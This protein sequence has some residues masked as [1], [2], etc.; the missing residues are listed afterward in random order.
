[1][2]VAVR[3]AM[4]RVYL[5]DDHPVVRAGLRAML[6]AAGHQVAGEAEDG[7]AAAAEIARLEPDVVVL[8]LQLG[9]SSGLELL[10]RLRQ[11]KIET[12]VVVLTLSTQPQ[13]IAEA[14][15]AG[16]IG[17]LAKGAVARELLAAIAEVAAGRRYLGSGIAERAVAGFTEGPS[18][19]PLSA[20]ERQIVALVVRG[21]S[22]AEVGAQLHLSPKTVDTY[23][24][25][26]MAKVGVD[27]LPA[28]VR[29]AVRE[30]LISLDE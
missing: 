25:R 23:R 17:Y 4:L 18:R 2:L 28:L 24:S 21:A 10:R 1:M 15:R 6:E 8:D 5:V 14:L 20:R 7:N 3:T 30:G 27:D 26:A 29:W 19:G 22:S 13:D 9:D 11:R 12:P 16:A